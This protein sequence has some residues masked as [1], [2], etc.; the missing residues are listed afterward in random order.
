MTLPALKECGVCGASVGRYPWSSY[1]RCDNGHTI[2]RGWEATDSHWEVREDVGQ[3]WHEEEAREAGGWWGVFNRM[4]GN[5]HYNQ[6]TDEY[7]WPMSRERAERYKQHID[8]DG[9]VL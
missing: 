6:M 5:P 8:D 1:W 9:I 2:C 7:A 4:T 3:R